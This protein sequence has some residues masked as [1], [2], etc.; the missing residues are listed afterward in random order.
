VK[1]ERSRR[2][3]T[4]EEPVSAVLTLP[5]ATFDIDSCAHVGLPLVLPVR[6]SGAGGDW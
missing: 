5:V 6:C 1:A 3:A 4:A 2:G